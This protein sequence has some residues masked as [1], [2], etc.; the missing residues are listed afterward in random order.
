[1]NWNK[2]AMYRNKE[3]P[4]INAPDAS[5]RKLVG[6]DRVFLT[7]SFE[8][9]DYDKFVVIISNRMIKPGKTK[10]IQKAID[11]ADLRNENEIKVRQMPN[12]SKY[13]G[14]FCLYDG[15]HRFVRA[16]LNGESFWYKLTAMDKSD[17]GMLA[18]S[19]TPWNLADSLRYYKVEE[20]S[21]DYK[22]LDA[23]RKQYKYPISTLI[24]ILSGQQNRIM[25]E[26]F[27]M[28]NFKV[29]QRL[30]YIHDILGKVQEFKQFSDRI[31]RHRTFLNVYI[32]LMSHPE[33][34]HKEMVQKVIKN[35]N[36]FI[37]CTKKEDYLRMLESIYNHQRQKKVRFY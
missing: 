33:F 4:M 37:F 16:M 35:P 28:G 8:T 9:K 3:V 6:D 15:Q 34:E 24:G 22:I 11:K 12:D 14:K 21:N 20:H 29:T 26:D 32:D 10:L 2:N 7:P 19:Q 18:N 27:R 5:D 17:I 25:L 31:Y 30:D 36:M 1:M 23:F 13:A